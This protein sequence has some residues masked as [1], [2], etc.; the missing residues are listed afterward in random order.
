[1]L[2]LLNQGKQAQAGG[3]DPTLQSIILQSIL[4]EGS[5]LVE[6]IINRNKIIK[7]N[8]SA[9]QKMEP[10]LWTPNS[11]L[12]MNPRPSNAISIIYGT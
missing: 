4:K 7:R 11:A 2:L 1:M 8:H 5:M 12:L 6:S 3:G 10:N 9:K